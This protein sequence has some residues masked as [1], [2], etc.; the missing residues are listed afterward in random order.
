MAENNTIPGEAIPLQEELFK[1][2]FDSSPLGI[3]LVTKELRFFS[4]NSAWEIMTGY[5]KRELLSL[6]VKD[7]THPDHISVDL[8]NI[9]MLM[10]EKIPV[11]HTEKRYTRKS[12][13]TR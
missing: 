7:I 5:P 2:I 10:E 12:G 4:V 6:T 13:S 11:Y 9:R 1:K 8:E 3:A